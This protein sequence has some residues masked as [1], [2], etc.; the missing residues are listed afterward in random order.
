MEEKKQQQQKK[1]TQ[2]RI[3]EERED[4]EEEKIRRE[5]RNKRKR[6]EEEEKTMMMMEEEEEEWRTRNNNNRKIIKKKY[7][8][9][10]TEIIAN[11]L[12]YIQMKER[13]NMR[14]I[15]RKWEIAVQHP[16][17]WRQLDCEEFAKNNLEDII[18][19][20][21]MIKPKEGQLRIK[22]IKI[23]STITYKTE[24][25]IKIAKIGGKNVETLELPIS[26]INRE[27]IKEDTLIKITEACTNIKSLNIATHNALKNTMGIVTTNC[28]QLERLNANYIPINT[29]TTKAYPRKLKKLS[30]LYAEATPINTN[31]LEYIQ[32]DC[33]QLTKLACKV[34]H[35]MQLD[36]LTNMIKLKTL[37]LMNVTTKQINQL[38]AYLPESGLQTLI[39]EGTKETTRI[40]HTLRLPK[41]L[42]TLSLT[43][44]AG[45][46]SI[47]GTPSLKSMSL[48]NIQ[49]MKGGFYNVN[50]ETLI[51]RHVRLTRLPSLE[52]VSQMELTLVSGIETLRTRHHALR[53]ASIYM[54]HE[55]RHIEMHGNDLESLSIDV[56]PQLEGLSIESNQ[57]QIMNLFSL[58]SEEAPL[59]NTLHVKA[60]KLKKLSLRRAIHLKRISLNTTQLE[61][62]N[63]A[64]CKQLN[65]IQLYAPQLQRLAL[66][67][68]H[69]HVSTIMQLVLPT[70]TMLSISRVNIQKE[71]LNELLDHFE[72]LQALILTNSPIKEVS[73]SSTTL[74]GIRFSACP[75]LIGVSLDT[76]ALVK[77]SFIDCPQL[78]HIPAVWPSALS[79]LTFEKCHNL[80]EPWFAAALSLSTLSFKECFALTQPRIE[81][82]LGCLS[83]IRFVNCKRLMGSLFTTPMMQR[84]E[85]L[86]E[87][88]DCDMSEAQVQDVFLRC[89]NMTLLGM[90]GVASL[91]QLMIPMHPSCRGVSLTS[92]EALE[93]VQVTPQAHQLEHLKVDTCS[94]LLTI[95][96]PTFLRRVEVSNCATLETLQHVYANMMVLRQN[97]LLKRLHP[98]MQMHQLAIS[99]CQSLTAPQQ[100]LF[101]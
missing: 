95:E 38:I 8:I 63:L 15:N 47:I 99:H 29:R 50:V 30:M 20:I 60:P 12:G 69:I 91:T 44:F 72:N 66:A 11:I 65:A 90:N 46:E 39:I 76:P 78:Y 98:N 58:S 17:L 24:T 81:P 10:T 9:L 6:K 14:R 2:K 25:L 93:R 31:Q 97:P 101:Y 74:T 70:L 51:L 26:N 21:D 43:N 42:K 13:I 67:A 100:P 1:E 80:Q 28:K 83:M 45:I 71:Q 35:D 85:C 16:T 62:L 64:N 87:F 92:C 41:G 7:T 82:T 32:R 94:A 3:E 52:H 18:K 68:P 86:V 36:A 84:V 55:L 79:S 89:P 57:L 23:P 22:H 61:S 48:S 27:S 59:L 34:T 88:H 53:F 4:K 73:L 37:H 49:Q 96:S 19:I 56:C 54:C 77:A 75:A 33:K 40:Q 5:K